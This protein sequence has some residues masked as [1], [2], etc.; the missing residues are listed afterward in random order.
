MWI[1]VALLYASLRSAAPAPDHGV[2]VVRDGGRLL[3]VFE[4]SSG[5]RFVE[6]GFDTRTRRCTSW[7][8]R[9]MVQQI[10]QH[11]AAASSSSAAAGIDGRE[12][13][14]RLLMLGLGGGMV[15]AQLLCQSSARPV[16]ASV[17]AVELS[18]VVVDA[19]WRDFYPATVEPCL[20]AG[21]GS[22]SGSNRSNSSSSS[23]SSSS[24]GSVNGSAGGGGGG[25]VVR[26]VHGDAMRFTAELVTN[27]TREAATAAAGSSSSSSSSSSSN[28]G[29]CFRYI[30]VDCFAMDDAAARDAGDAGDAG[31]G[32]GR[33]RPV[34]P[35][36]T[37]AFLGQ[38]RALMCADDALLLINTTPTD[39]DAETVPLLADV[40]RLF[41]D[42]RV[43]RK[44]K[45][46][47]SGYNVVVSASVRPQN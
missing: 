40:S 15:I 36:F 18:R 10:S 19:W 13:P 43:R 30:V 11:A 16:V 4:T 8:G 45:E 14:P 23:S 12:E 47:L 26:V 2:S 24:R 7:Y 6:S 5:E 41:N 39:Y 27:R 33:A 1:G 35:P 9:E 29:G 28:D 3:L 38:L 42:V 44:R 20:G 46:V 22:C 34:E 25:G 21:A 17:L 31:G 32:G 37:R